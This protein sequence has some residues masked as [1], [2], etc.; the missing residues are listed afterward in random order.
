MNDVLSKHLSRKDLADLLALSYS[1]LSCKTEDQLKKLILD[2][3][4]LFGFENMVCAQAKVPDALTHPSPNVFVLDVSYPDGYMDTY[5]EKGYHLTDAVLCEFLTNLSP[6]NWERIDKRLGCDYPAAQLA[7]D[8][9]I[10]YGWT[11]GTV[12]TASMNC[13]AIFMAGPQIDASIRTEK[14][15]GYIIPFYMEA[16]SRV[17][18]QPSSPAAKLTAREIEVLHWIKEG[19]SSWEISQIL[20]CSKRGVDFHTNSI[21]T[22]LNA[23]SRPQAVAIGLHQGIIKF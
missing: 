16:Y 23:V 1:S 22:K 17:L 19:K 2:L 11:H 9:N 6:V 13:T 5:L 18:G 10:R 7:F 15:L 8:A 4:T 14:M 3:K 12:D 20:N 21:K